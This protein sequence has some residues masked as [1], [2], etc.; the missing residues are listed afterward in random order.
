MPSE[1]KTLEID[2]RVP[3]NHTGFQLEAG[4]KYL[5]RAVAVNDAEGHAYADKVIPCTPDGP[6]GF[7]GSLFEFVARDARCPLNPFHWLG[8]GSIKRL[9]VLNDQTCRR[10]SFLTV[11]A[12]VGEDDREENTFVIGSEREITAHA[13]G[14][15]VIFCND[16]P[17]GCGR[18]GE[19]RFQ[20]S[21]S[22]CNNRGLIH[23]TIESR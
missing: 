8:P 7:R 18:D 15:L 1:N 23:L 17:G 11:M 2:P 6:S 12:A 10:A 3:W 16:W 19:A 20:E 22:Y 4:H 14:E 9:R 21:R 13:T 5:L